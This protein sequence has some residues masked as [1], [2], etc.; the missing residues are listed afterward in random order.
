[1]KT[2]PLTQNQFALVDDEDYVAVMAA[3]PWRAWCDRGIF[4]AVHDVWHSDIK[5]MRVIFMHHVIVGEGIGIDHRNRNGLDNQ[6]Q[7]LRA[8][9]Q[10][11]N[12][13]NRRK[14]KTI[15]GHAPSSQYKGVRWHKG[16]N[17][18]VASLRFEGVYK[19]LGHF[20]KEED[21][22]LAYNIAAWLT[23]GEFANFNILKDLEN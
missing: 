1:M 19:H 9:T 20:Q 11:Q 21:A 12:L 5:Q 7:N 23:Y 17:V 10:A 3:G 14:F 8:A 6:K 4:Y 18:W 13:R 15:C 22:A 16:R 2:I